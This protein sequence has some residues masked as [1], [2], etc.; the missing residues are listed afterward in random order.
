MSRAM[1][2]AA[3]GLAL[4]APAL[5]E[6]RPQPD[7]AALIG[8]TLSPDRQSAIADHAAMAKSGAWTYGLT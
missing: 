5:A 1:M 2:A 8:K 3:L 7:A 6:D 4:A